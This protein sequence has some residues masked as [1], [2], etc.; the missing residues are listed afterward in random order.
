[1]VFSVLAFAAT[2]FILASAPLW[3]HG[4]T[5]SAWVEGDRVYTRSSFSGGQVVAGSSVMVFDQ[6]GKELL[7]GKT[8]KQGEFSFKAPERTDLTI[9]LKGSMG[10][11]AECRITAAQL[12]GAAHDLS[13]ETAPV[14]HVER[15]GGMPDRAAGLS[16]E[17]VQA[18]IDKSLERK[19]A[20]IMRRLSQQAGRGPGL[21]QVIGGLGYIVGLVGVALYVANRRR[22]GT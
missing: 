9:V 21:S 1:M 2:A 19:L 14:T 16:R 8:D 15:S 18:L 7:A 6:Q 17:E 20:P 10:H 12:K 3:A 13:P 22:K 4:V 5:I 11:R